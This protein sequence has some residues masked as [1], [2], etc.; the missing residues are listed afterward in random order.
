[1]K[2]KWTVIYYETPDKRCPIE[3]FI[4]SRSNKNQAKIMAMISYLE[5][6]GPNLPRPYADLLVDGIHELRI[7]LS[8]EQIRILYFFCYKEF[9]VLSHSFIKNESAV[10]EA[11][12][13]KA[14]AARI[15]FCK[16]YNEKDLKVLVNEDIQKTFRK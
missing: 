16:R 2:N 11:Q 3:A 1:M 14:K 6:L 5:E 15:D 7:K 12:I 8:G 4:D 9:I 13:K 10:L